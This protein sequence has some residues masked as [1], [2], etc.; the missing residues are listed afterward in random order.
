M[1]KQYDFLKSVL[2][3]LKDNEFLAAWE[4]LEFKTSP[5]NWFAIIF[6]I[7]LGIVFEIVFMKI[8]TSFQRKPALS[9]QR[10]PSSQEII[11]LPLQKEGSEGPFEDR[12]PP[13]DGRPE[14]GSNKNKLHRSYFRESHGSFTQAS[15]S[16]VSMAHSEVKK[17][18]LNHQEHPES[19][20]ETVQFSPK[21]LFSTMKNKNPNALKSQDVKKKSLDSIKPGSSPAQEV[22][23][24]LYSPDNS[25]SIESQD[26]TKTLVSDK[27]SSYEGLAH[28]WVRDSNKRKDSTQKK[29]TM[30]KDSKQ[31]KRKGLSSITLYLINVSKPILASKTNWNNK[32]PLKDPVIPAKENK[33]AEFNVPSSKKLSGQHVLECETHLDK[34]IS[35]L[36]QK[37]ISYLKMESN[38]R[39]ERMKVLKSTESSVLPSNGEMGPTSKPEVGKDPSVIQ[40][41]ELKAKKDISRIIEVNHSV[42]RQEEKPNEKKTFREET[43]RL[44]MPQLVANSH[45]NIA[46]MEPGLS[47]HEQ[48]APQMTQDFKLSQQLK[49]KVKCLQFEIQQSSVGKSRKPNEEPEFVEAKTNEIIYS[50]K[51]HDISPDAN[52]L[53]EQAG[54]I[55]KEK[56]MSFDFSSPILSATKR[57]S[58]FKRPSDIG[59]VANFKCGIT[60]V[61]KPFISEVLHIQGGSC[62]KQREK[63]RSN[64]ESQMK[65][66]AQV[67]NMADTTD[68]FGTVMS[69]IWINSKID[70]GEKRLSSKH[71]KETVSPLGGDMTSCF[72][73]F[74]EEEE[75][76]SEKNI[77]NTIQHFTFQSGQRKESDLGRSE[78]QGNGKILFLTEQAVSQVQLIECVKLEESKTR[79]LSPDVMI[80][81]KDKSSSKADIPVEY[82]LCSE[83]TG[84]LIT[85][86]Q[87]GNGTEEALRKAASYSK[88]IL[89]E[90]KRQKSNRRQILNQGIICHRR[91]ILKLKVTEFLHL[92]H[93]IDHGTHSHIED[94]QL[95]IT[96][97]TVDMKHRDEVKSDIMALSNTKQTS[98]E[99]PINRGGLGN[100][101]QSTP[102]FSQVKNENGGNI[103]KTK[104]IMDLRC[105][106]F[107][108]KRTPFKHVFFEDEPQ[109]N[110]REQKKIMQ[111]APTRICE[112]PAN[113]LENCMQKEEDVTLKDEG[114]VERALE[115]MSHLDRIAKKEIVSPITQGVELIKEKEIQKERKKTE[116]KTKPY[117]QKSQLAFQER[118]KGVEKIK[119]KASVVLTNHTSVSVLSHVNSCTQTRK[120]D[121]PTDITRYPLP[122][123]PQRKASAAVKKTIDHEL[124]IRKGEDMQGIIRYGILSPPLQTSFDAG[125]ILHAKSNEDDV[126]MDA[127][128]VQKHK[129]QNGEDRERDTTI[130]KYLIAKSQEGV[131]RECILD[132]DQMNLKHRTKKS[133]LFSLL[134]TKSLQVNIKEQICSKRREPTLQKDTAARE[135]D[136]A[137]NTMADSNEMCLKS[138][139]S[140]SSLRSSQGNI[141]KTETQEQRIPEGQQELSDDRLTNLDA[142]QAPPISQRVDT[143]HKGENIEIVTRFSIATVKLKESLESKEAIHLVPVSFDVLIYP[144]TRLQSLEQGN[145]GDGV[146]SG[147]LLCSKHR[148][149]KVEEEKTQE[150]QGDG[151][152]KNEQFESQREKQHE[153]LAVDLRV[154]MHPELSRGSPI[155]QILNSKEFVLNLIEQKKKVHGDREELCRVLTRNFI[156]VPT[157]PT[158]VKNLGN[159]IDKDVPEKKRVFFPRCNH[160]QSSDIQERTIG[161]SLE[162]EGA[163]VVKKAKHPAKRQEAA[164]K[165]ASHFQISIWE[166]NLPPVRSKEELNQLI[167]S[168]QS[169]KSYFTGCVTIRNGEGLEHSR[170]NAQLEDPSEA[171]RT[172]PSAALLSHPTQ[173]LRTVDNW[174]KYLEIKGTFDQKINPKV[175][176]ASLIKM[177]LELCITCGSP[178]NSKGFSVLENEPQDPPFKA[179]PVWEADDIFNNGRRHANSREAKALDAE[180]NIQLQKKFTKRVLGSPDPALPLSPKCE[181]VEGRFTRVPVKWN[182]TPQCLTM[183]IPNHPILQLLGHV[184]KLEFDSVQPKEIT[185][186][187]ENG[188][189]IYHGNLYLSR[190]PA[191][192]AEET[193]GAKRDQEKE[194]SSCTLEPQKSVCT[195]RTVWKIHLT[196]SLPRDAQTLEMHTQDTQNNPGAASEAD[197]NIRE[198]E[199]PLTPHMEE[200]AISGHDVSVLP[201]DPMV[202]QQE[203]NVAKAI[204]FTPEKPKE[205][206]EMSA[207]DWTVEN[208]APGA[209]ENQDEVQPVLTQD[210]NPEQ[211]QQPQSLVET[212]TLPPLQAEGK[213]R[214]LADWKNTEENLLPIV[215][216]IQNYL[217]SQITNIIQEKFLPQLESR[218]TCPQ[219]VWKSPPSTEAPDPT[220][221]PDPR[222]QAKAISEC[223]TPQGEMNLQR[224]LVLNAQEIHSNGSPQKVRQSSQSCSLSSKEKVTSEDV[225]RMDSPAPK[226]AS[227]VPDE[228]IETI[229]IS[230]RHKSPRG[231]ALVNPLKSLNIHFAD[232]DNKVLK[233]SSTRKLESRAC[234]MM[235]SD[236]QRSWPP[237]LR[238]CSIELRDKLLI[239]LGRKT[240]EIQMKAFPRPARASYIAA[241]T[242]QKKPMFQLSPGHQRPKYPN[243]TIL[244][245]DQKSLHPKDLDLQ[246]KHV[247]FFQ[248]IPVKRRFPKP[249]TL[250]K[251]TLKLNTVVTCKNISQHVQDVGL[252]PDREQEEKQFSFRNQ[253]PQ[254]SQVL[255]LP[256]VAELNPDGSRG[257]ERDIIAPPEL[258]HPVTMEKDKHGNVWSQRTALCPCL[259]PQKNAGDSVQFQ[260]T[261]PP[262]V[263][264]KRGLKASKAA[265]QPSLSL[266]DS[267]KCMV[268]EANSH[269]AQESESILYELQNGVPLES[270]MMKKIN[271]EMMPFVK[272]ALSPFQ[273]WACR[274]HSLSVTPPHWESHRNR[275]RRP[276]SRRH[277]P[278]QG[279]GR[280]INTSEASGKSSIIIL[281]EKCLPTMRNKM[282]HSVAPLTE[283]NLRLHLARNQGRPSRSPESRERKK[284]TSDI[285]CKNHGPQN[286]DHS[287][288]PRQG[289][290][291]RKKP[292]LDCK[293]VPE[294]S[295]TFHYFSCRKKLVWKPYQEAPQQC[296][297]RRTHPPF[298][299]ACIPADSME[300]IPRTVRWT[301]PPQ[302]LRKNNFRVPLVAKVYSSCRLDGDSHCPPSTPTPEAEMEFC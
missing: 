60:K 27:K 290:Y 193:K 145:S 107:K 11:S 261:R 198:N 93:S 131:D 272:E 301:I 44:K 178:A 53:K 150:A 118:E 285:F 223:S 181:D 119:S 196:N 163:I 162:R 125:K 242:Q 74:Q 34:T 59:M 214:K 233:W 250:P 70:K 262:E 229:E 158:F 152:N 151:G 300:I 58:S 80:P 187:D 36:L 117:S 209:A 281:Q 30:C 123:S 284:A 121:F 185:L 132:K 15:S 256:P 190:E 79:H 226:K 167:L 243:R 220:P 140:F 52:H 259:R 192:Q 102:D 254:Q 10:T 78:D 263:F 112:E 138:K 203:E 246:Y 92:L 45:H 294:H 253:R 76:V 218:S 33:I 42:Q 39:L 94:L 3:V 266:K 159:K 161:K 63:L 111:K 41:S 292:T 90:S 210:T 153:V 43:Y 195:N 66:M 166:K 201:T 265:S 197:S 55:G 278:G 89:T 5:Y 72:T 135:K 97:E 16:S 54:S 282:N 99:E 7:F 136:M 13:M 142:S 174:K 200:G 144:L 155:S 237:I 207:K 216:S 230:L 147:L 124:D 57:K 1:S 29:A 202:Q 65:E 183:K 227:C 177:P 23:S 213:E 154:K 186:C 296:W 205:A 104:A 51:E 217:E 61:K 62:T 160:Q 71:I 83:G 17:I 149:E 232:T 286:Q 268:L 129:P 224:H 228:D 252:A 277:F 2:N 239:H 238:R 173:T 172:P 48:N 234:F 264:L 64:S 137:L 255:G 38:R 19:E 68:F 6:I 116:V 105:V 169:K 279:S 204:P 293:D 267:E 26:A 46:D 95:N 240:L 299:Y 179:S 22:D 302:T 260:A 21:K 211:P 257:E 221:Q 143:G 168:P 156:S 32:E 47:V 291:P 84:L 109:W 222:E 289:K 176:F 103:T 241:H 133:P 287:N 87:S 146:K 175:L 212:L 56:T 165:Q 274:R 276:S 40:T 37:L 148:E 8:C 24:R 110:H 206:V 98:S 18:F 157:V 184:K 85:R 50:A 251:Y 244:L 236:I 91:R 96:E 113:N 189:E 86:D 199:V 28:V 231:A 164:G 225:P 88:P 31:Q 106:T 298:V 25:Y 4:L 288:M 20:R 247:R 295:G 101:I 67:L 275:K 127:K 114:T 170:I 194:K 208:S 258:T 191:L 249:K 270:L 171:P 141:Q 280:P 130:M 273:F 126:S 73:S 69:D 14:F 271:T 134:L 215:E 120:S 49:Q 139:E 9:G 75:E 180:Q 182:S 219:A 12:V 188:T 122:K 248:Q 115:E 128:T 35:H 82:P 283:S 297:K 108:R 81:M 77:L 235:A 245:L 100:V 269:L